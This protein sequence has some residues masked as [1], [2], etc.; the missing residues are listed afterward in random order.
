VDGC[1]SYPDPDS[2]GSLLIDTNAD[3]V[4]QSVPVAIDAFRTHALQAIESL[5]LFARV[6]LEELTKHDGWLDGDALSA[7]ERS[8]ERLE[9]ESPL[10]VDQDL[11]PFAPAVHA[12][13]ERF[14]L[15]VQ[16]VP[17]GKVTTHPRPRQSLPRRQRRYL[18]A[19]YDHT[20]LYCQRPGG[21]RDPDGNDWQI[22]HIVPRSKGGSEA[23]SNKCLSC[24]RCNQSKGA[25]SLAEFAGPHLKR[26]ESRIVSL[27]QQLP[28]PD[29]TAD[30]ST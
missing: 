29:I 5:S 2:A 20:C 30:S 9:R 13:L 7:L 6:Y 21:R 10:A 12:A 18:L 25:K 3:A 19:L 17:S 15:R 16:A 28:P 4:G 14:G 11:R 23:L 24:R 27:N 8:R 26:I 1:K 22:D